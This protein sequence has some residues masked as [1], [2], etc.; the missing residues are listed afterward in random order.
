MKKPGALIAL[1]TLLLLS[2]IVHGI[3]LAWPIQWLWNNSLVNA[4]NGIHPISFWRAYGIFILVSLFI[5]GVTN[6]NTKK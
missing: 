4:I 5:S 2:T 3:I 1:G 6:S